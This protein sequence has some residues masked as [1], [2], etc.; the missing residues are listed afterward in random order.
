M[1]KHLHFPA[2]ILILILAISCRQSNKEITLAS[3]LN[4][5]TDRNI[6]TKFPVPAFTV[7]QFSSYDRRS[8]SPDSTGWFANYDA[9]WFLREENNGERREFVMF[10]ADG[11]GAVVRFWMTFG[12]KNAYSGTIRFYFDGSDNPEIE[13][14]VLDIISGGALVGEPLSSSVS[15]ESDYSR[16][17]HN[18]YLPIPYSR[19]LKITYE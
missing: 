6:V 2:I 5:M 7:K 17:G 18:L 4:E 8:V 1:S 11:P 13:G 9:S 16:R 3:L 12:N 10:D 14:P 19:H 15:P